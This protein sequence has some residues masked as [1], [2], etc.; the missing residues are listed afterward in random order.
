MEKYYQILG[1]DED[2]SVR[3]IKKAYKKLAKT[4]HPD[5]GGSEFLFQQVQ[6]AYEALTKDRGHQPNLYEKAVNYISSL[7]PTSGFNQLFE[8][9]EDSQ[10]YSESIQSVQHNGVGKTNIIVNNNG[11]VQEEEFWH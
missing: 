4:L 9:D 6:H 7:F 11:N 5:K 1:I 3:E 8:D 10:F 2:A